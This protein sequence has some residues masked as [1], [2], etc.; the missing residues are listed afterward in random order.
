MSCDPGLRPSSTTLSR[1]R[2]EVQD[3]SRGLLG[4]SVFRGVRRWVS[5]QSRAVDLLFRIQ[6][7]LLFRL[8]RARDRQPARRPGEERGCGAEGCRWGLAARTWHEI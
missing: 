5:R 8:P 3:A 6:A 1:G 7:T 2:G 4:T